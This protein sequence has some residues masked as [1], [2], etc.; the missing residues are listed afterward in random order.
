[1]IDIPL[2]LLGGMGISF[3]IMAF[4]DSRTFIKNNNT[5]IIVG[6]IF[7]GIVWELFEIYYNI[8]GY[9]VGTK[10]YY[11]DTAKDLVN[12]TLGAVIA[13]WFIRS[14]PFKFLWKKI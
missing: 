9:D 6:S 5:F 7:V 1:M 11:I 14:N 8:T 13:L 3:F 10:M 12:D 4:L 2:H